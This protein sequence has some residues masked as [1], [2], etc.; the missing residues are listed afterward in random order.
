[1]ECPPP[2]FEFSSAISPAALTFR[3]CFAERQLVEVH[4]ALQSTHRANGH[5][6]AW[7]AAP[8]GPRRSDY[9][10]R[11]VDLAARGFELYRVEVF[12]GL[13]RRE[14]SIRGPGAGQYFLGIEGRNQRP[15][16]CL[17]D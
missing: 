15:D 13:G 7:S 3:E 5:S 4:E 1:M 17:M 11:P 14:Q 16:T 6:M 9:H 2:Y 8:R 12:D 10:W